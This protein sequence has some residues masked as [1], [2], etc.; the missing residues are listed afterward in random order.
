MTVNEE[1]FMSGVVSELHEVAAQL[2]ILNKNLENLN[3]KKT[4]KDG[5][6][7]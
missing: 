7:C 2:K 6:A 3:L 4:K 5:P 1:R